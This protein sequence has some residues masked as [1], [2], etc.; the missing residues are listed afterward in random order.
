MVAPVA[1]IWYVV[2]WVGS[3]LLS[4]PANSSI[5]RGVRRGSVTT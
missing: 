1:S 4:T 2:I 5:L 3:T